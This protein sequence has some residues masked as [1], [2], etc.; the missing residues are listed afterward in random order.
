MFSWPFPRDPVLPDLPF[1]R[2]T[3]AVPEALTDIPSAVREALDKLPDPTG[4][5]VGIPVGSRGIDRLAEVLEA[6]IQDLRSRGAEPILVPAMGSH[7]GG[8][9]EGRRE[10]LQHL[11]LLRR[12]WPWSFDDTPVPVASLGRE[13]L[14]W[15]RALALADRVLPI[16]RVKGHPSFGGNL[17]SGP[18]KMLVVGMG[19]PEGARHF[20]EGG[21]EALPDRLAASARALLGTGRVLGGLAL[22]EGPQKCLVRIAPERPKSFVEDETRLLQDALRLQGR[23]PL[24]EMDI[25]I[26]K[27]VG[28]SI[29]GTGVDTRVVGRTGLPGVSQPDAPQIRRLVGLDLTR[30]SHGNANGMGLLDVIT[31]RFFDRIDFRSTYLNVLT[32]TFTDRARVPVVLPTEKAAIAAAFQTLTPPAPLPVVVVIDDTSHLEHM[33]VSMSALSL[34]DP[35]PVQTEGPFRLETD[36]LRFLP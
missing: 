18:A 10:V 23:L 22:L 11:G 34:L 4:Q 27:Q 21:P 17:G 30:E 24:K 6:A 36:P 13:P 33:H 15:P 31:Q 25:L 20:H 8:T 14:F 12:E 19:G 35:K 9:P 29:S 16:N 28:K 32:T 2:V 1:F 7:G 26:V 5:T 3:F